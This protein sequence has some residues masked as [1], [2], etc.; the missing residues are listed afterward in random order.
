[1]PSLRALP[2][3]PPAQADT[4]FSGK[5]VLGAHRVAMRRAM[6]G[7]DEHSRE[8]AASDLREVAMEQGRVIDVVIAKVP[9]AP[10]L[11]QAPGCTP[12]LIPN[13]L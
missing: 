7:Q 6:E 8:L 12:F 3:R 5:N 1:M 9:V 13:L 2:A 10:A 11:P 4:L